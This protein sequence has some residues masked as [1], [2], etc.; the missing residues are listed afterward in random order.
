MAGCLIHAGE[1]LAAHDYLST[2]IFIGMGAILYGLEA[3]VK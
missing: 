2:L 1:L 3:E